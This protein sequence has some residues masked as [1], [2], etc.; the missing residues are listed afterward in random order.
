[1]KAAGSDSSLPGNAPG[2]SA[3]LPLET[4]RLVLR[5]FR[6]SDFPDVHDYASD[7][8]VTRHLRWGP[9][10][11]SE[12]LRFLRRVIAETR[13]PDTSRFDL[14]VVERKTVRVRGGMSL[15]ERA[16]GVVEIGYVLARPVW[17][18]GYASEAVRAAVRFADVRF[19]G[20]ELFGLVL[21]GNVASERVLLRAGF[22]PAVDSSPYEPWMDGLCS[23][24]RAFR[25]Q[26]SREP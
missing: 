24:A 2:R 10:P 16:P 5:P 12:T 8:E 4:A 25:R 7:P 1:M 13:A 22:E 18:F 21:P 20:A 19:A 3:G 11:A 15:E 14:A 17:G 6:E 26:C 9:N 23:T